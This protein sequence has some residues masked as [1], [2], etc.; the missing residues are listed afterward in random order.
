MRV[1]LSPAKTF[2]KDAPS[3]AAG[4]SQ[5]RFLKEASTLMASLRTLTP[6]ELSPLMDISPA[7]AEETAAK[8]L[9]W[10]TPFHP[11]NSVLAILAFHGEVYRA[12]G[13]ERWNATDLDFAQGKLRI[14][15][16]L[17]GLLHPLDLIQPYRL[18]MGLRWAPG[19]EGNLY[20]HWG[21]SLSDALAEDADGA[22]IVNLASQEYAKAVKLAGQPGPV[23]TCHFKEERN[24]GFKMIGTYAK[25]ARG[26]MAKFIVQERVENIDGLQAFCEEGYRFNSHLSNDSEW[27]FTRPTPH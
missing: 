22:P 1:L 7:L 25:H 14:L 11:G 9:D 27:T 26:L 17:Y 24:G 4:A 13:A 10:S 18:E 12:M 20:T 23:I 16:G 2:R 8:H 21:D 6:A 15:S 3:P 5:P 19:Q